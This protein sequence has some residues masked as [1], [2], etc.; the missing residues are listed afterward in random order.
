VD[1]P[2]HSALQYGDLGS[3]WCFPAG[4][5]VHPVGIWSKAVSLRP[6]STGRIDLHGAYVAGTVTVSIN[7]TDQPTLMAGAGDYQ[8]DLKAPVV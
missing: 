2:D 4:T 7:M 8:M 1:Q 5:G 3:S 6:A